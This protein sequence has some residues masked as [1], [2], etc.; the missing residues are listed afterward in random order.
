MLEA[1]DVCMTVRGVKEEKAAA[2]ATRVDRITTLMVAVYVW[3]V[4]V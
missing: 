4:V 1:V 3:L 2:V